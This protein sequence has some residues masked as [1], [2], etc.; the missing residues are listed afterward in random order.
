VEIDAFLADSVV[1]AEGKLYAQGAGW[2]II[3]TSATPMRHPRIGLGALVRVAFTET[4]QEHFFTVKIIDQDGN[5]LPIFEAPA[6][7]ETVDGKIYEWKGKFNVGRPP[8]LAPGDAQIIP[9]AVNIDGLVFPTPTM[10]SVVISIDDDE[11]KRLP[12]RI[13]MIGS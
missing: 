2:N 9:L 10:Y 8:S 3:R 1:V 11:M 5:A 13:Q 12:M 4:N 7:V 6:N